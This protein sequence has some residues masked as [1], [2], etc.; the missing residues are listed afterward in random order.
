MTNTVGGLV[1]NGV[2]K[3]PGLYNSSNVSA[4][5]GA[6]S[7]L[8]VP[9]VNTSST[10]IISSVSGGVLSLTWPADHTGWRLQVQTNS[11]A[12]GLGTNWVDVAGA[13]ATNQVNLPV[14]SANGSVFYRL[15]YP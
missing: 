14:S 2:T 9:P 5:T 15:V 11:L 13:T 10:N 3:A 7:L 6:G 12:K 8:V 4:I 1:V